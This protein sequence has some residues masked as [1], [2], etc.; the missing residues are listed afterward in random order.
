MKK[1][2]ERLKALEESGNLRTIAREDTHDNEV[3]LSSNDYLGIASDRDFIEN[4]YSALKPEMLRP[5]SSASRLLAGC[6]EEYTQLE[7]ELSRLYER[8]ALLFNSGYHANTGIIKAL[9]DKDTLFLADKLVH[10]SIIDG[11]SLAVAGGSKMMR[12]AHND[13]GHLRRLL[14]AHGH[15]YGR[16]VIVAES[17]YSMDGDMADLTALVEVKKLHDNVILYVDEA[18][19]VGVVG[20]KG[21]G[22]SRGHA[23][24]DE[25]DIV[26]GTFG[27][28]LASMGAYAVTTDMMKEYLVN[29]SRSLIFST[30]ISPLTARWSL[31]TLRYAVEAEE[32]R[33]RLEKL[34]KKLQEWVGGDVDGHI[35]PLLIGNPTEALQASALL[36][37][38]G[39]RVLPIRT[40]T[41][42]AGTDRLRFSLSASLRNVDIER[43]GFVLPGVLE[44]V[45]KA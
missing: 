39:F 22:L 35:Q 31:A 4:F 15:E 7:D 1:I 30:A 42:P 3:D 21:L 16:V 18:H 10:A 34:G 14:T 6:Q 2:A 44:K 13:Y 23:Q 8:P 41:V 32:K 9:G 25:I 29:M 43:L 26:V 17:V 38:A 24:Y 19:A 36:K 45:K 5:T 37:D 20:E 28:A 12:F 40:P 33:K 11:M 27:K